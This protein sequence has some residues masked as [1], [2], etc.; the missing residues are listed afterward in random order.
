MKSGVHPHDSTCRAWRHLRSHLSS[1]V[2]ALGLVAPATVYPCSLEQL[3]SLPFER[4]LQLEILSQ[5][6]RN[7][8]PYAMRAALTGGEQVP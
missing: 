3:L 7:A 2:L 4:L 1:V 8:G 5:L 6:G